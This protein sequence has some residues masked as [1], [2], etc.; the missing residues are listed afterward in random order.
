V[1]RYHRR[2]RPKKKHVTYRALPR[3]LRQ[4][5]RA[6]SAI[7][8]VAEGLDRSQSQIVRDVDVEDRGADVLLRLHLDGDAELELWA[9]QRHL[10]PLARL[11]GKPVR[12][13][14]RGVGRSA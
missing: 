11:I 1:A 3:P 8:A 13:E 7:V 2:G 5:V 4:A 10:G 14:T 6:L 9:T 12:L